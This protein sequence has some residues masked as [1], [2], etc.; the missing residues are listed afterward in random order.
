MLLGSGELGKEFAIAAQRLGNTVI[1]VDR[2]AHA[3]AMQVADA[4]AVIS[5][6]D[7][8]ALEAVVQE[9][10]PDLIIPKLKQSEPRNCR[11]LKTVA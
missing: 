1:A 3:P 11:S 8:E 7:G 10:Q 4:S 9:F 5:M 2:Y 6:L